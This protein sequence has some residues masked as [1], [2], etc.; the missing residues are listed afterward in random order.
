MSRHTPLQ[1]TA[2]ALVVLVGV[3]VLAPSVAGQSNGQNGGQSMRDRS[4]PL[5]SRWVRSPLQQ[6]NAPDGASVLDIMN[7]LN[8]TQFAD[9]LQRAGYGGYLSGQ[10]QGFINVFCPI[11]AS[12]QNQFAQLNGD[13]LYNAVANMIVLNNTVQ[14][15]QGQVGF[16]PRGYAIKVF[17]SFWSSRWYAILERTPAVG[18]MLIWSN[19]SAG[20]NV[21]VLNRPLALEGDGIRPY[22]LQ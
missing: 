15:Y 14:L 16:T 6:Y 9:A 8:C 2:A 12:V 17:D 10:Q 3:A 13:S 19:S 1:L 20:G 18:R 22:Q 11:D 21:F 4:I 7:T 5:I